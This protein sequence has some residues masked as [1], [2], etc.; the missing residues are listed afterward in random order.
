MLYVYTPYVGPNMNDNVIAFR[1]RLVPH[2]FCVIK[3]V[4]DLICNSR[5][6][7]KCATTYIGKVRVSDHTHT[8]PLTQTYGEHCDVF[9]ARLNK[10]VS[11]K[12]AQTCLLV[13]LM[14]T[15]AAW[16]LLFCFHSRFG[17]FLAVSTRLYVPPHAVG[18]E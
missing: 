7:R 6:R 17:G 4:F 10:K 18:P 1:V 2:A 14:S 12:V 3:H 9:L 13:F 16:S 11:N 15:C 5:S 8:Q